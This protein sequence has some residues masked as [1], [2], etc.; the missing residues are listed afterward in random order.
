M[1]WSTVVSINKTGYGKNGN[2]AWLNHRNVGN[3]SCV[4]NRGRK[5]CRVSSAGS[6]GL[7]AL[8]SNV[9][10]CARCRNLAACTNTLIWSKR[11][12]K[13][14]L[15]WSESSLGNSSNVVC[16]LK[17]WFDGDE[18][19]DIFALLAISSI[20]S[21]PILIAMFCWCWTNCR[22]Y[23]T[24]FKNGKKI[25]LQ[26]Q[27]YLYAQVWGLLELRV[28]FPHNAMHR[29][30]WLLQWNNSNPNVSVT[31]RTARLLKP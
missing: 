16:L 14:V 13:E 3:T 10:A 4:R 18:W 9:F 30:H 28:D 17:R 22:P 23:W 25:R 27:Y 15:S 2:E 19:D 1:W 31:V 8:K 21:Q 11:L 29:I 26:G 6:W 5:K 12:G 24:E 7:L 20:L